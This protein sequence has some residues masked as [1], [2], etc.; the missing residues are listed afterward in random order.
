MLDRAAIEETI[1]TYAAAWA[2]S[3]REGWL[4]TFAD[5]A[6]QEDPVGEGVRRGR[7]EIGEFWDRAMTGYESLEIVP[8]NIFVVGREAAME[9][10]IKAATPEG[11]ITFE[12]VDVF[13]FDE[14]ACIVSVRAYWEQE[15]VRDQR[16]HLA[17][18]GRRSEP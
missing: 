15:R 4:D 1:R 11:T 18:A 12:G 10:T 13:T 8:R 9:W 2:A 14:A 16:Q 3:D 7:D 6:T 17:A 5:C